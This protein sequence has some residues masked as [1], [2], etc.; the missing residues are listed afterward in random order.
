MSKWRPNN[1]NCLYV[2]P[3]IH[4][5]HELLQKILKRILPLRKSDGGQDKI[6]FLG[7][8]I[9]RHIDSHKVIDALID[10]K[11]RYKNNIICLCGNHELMM[12]E[13]LGYISSSNKLSMYDMWIQEGGLQTALGYLQRAGKLEPDSFSM[14]YD[15][16]PEQIRRCIPDEHVSFLMNDMLPFYEEDNFVFVHG[17]YDPRQSPNDFAV[18]TLCWDRSLFKAV[19]RAVA[20]SN[21]LPWEKVVVTGHNKSGP[22]PFINSKFMMLDC[23]SPAR[24]L[25]T[26]MRSME[27]FMSLPNKKRLIK[28]KLKETIFKK[29]PGL[30]RRVQ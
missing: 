3:D 15:L 6:V 1:L 26:E 19:Q 5:A 22:E 24:L 30:I 4:G 17:G 14:N 25:V 23:G 2:I 28:F 27:A 10:L 18:D 16:D 20:S 11:K 29:K 7:D 13:A 21:E 12:L 9:D 8:Y